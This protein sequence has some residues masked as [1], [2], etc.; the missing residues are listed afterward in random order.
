MSRL[1]KNSVHSN[2]NRLMTQNPQHTINGT[3]AVIRTDNVRENWV[4]AVT[5][6]VHLP[7]VWCNN[8]IHIIPQINVGL[9]M[10]MNLLRQNWIMKPSFGRK[11]SIIHISTNK[12]STF[13]PHGIPLTSQ[14][15]I[16]LTFHGILLWLLFHRYARYTTILKYRRQCLLKHVYVLFVINYI[17][18]PSTFTIM[19][20]HCNYTCLLFADSL[21]AGAYFVW[22]ATSFTNLYSKKSLF[23]NGACTDFQEL[24]FSSRWQV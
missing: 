13:T 3:D 21:K 7:Y 2:T 10:V 22:L 15:T 20:V 4:F 12:L 16:K 11:I 5:E 8:K 18:V 1:H 14:L 23:D 9:D 17:V 6:S 19:L 24:L